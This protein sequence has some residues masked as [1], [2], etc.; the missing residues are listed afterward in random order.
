MQALA[1]ALTL[2]AMIVAT[3]FL[4]VAKVWWFAPLASNWG[5]LDTLIVI[6]FAVTGLA[7]VGVNLFIAYSVYYHRAQKDRKALFFVDNPRLEWGLIA[8]TTVGIVVLLGPGL[9]YY[10]QLIRP[11]QNHMVVEVLTQQ[12]L[13]SYRY[14]GK[15]GV[16]G[17]ASIKRFTPANQFGL[18]P[19]APASQDDI[20]VLGGPLALPVGQPVLLRMRSNDVIH[21]FYVPEFRVKWDVVPGMVTE[22]WFT[23]TKTGEFQV[24]C[25]ELCGVGHYSMVGKVVVMEPDA[26]Q[27]WLSERPTVAQIFGPSPK[28]QR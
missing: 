20:P 9:Y 8:V 17:P 18:D 16:L 28:A 19:Q 6:T 13:W 5:S 12:W 26:F 15:D 27:K 4:T 11:P 22:V 2:V 24:I 25:A 21:S 10:A 7:L 14:P 23:P 1:V 3:I